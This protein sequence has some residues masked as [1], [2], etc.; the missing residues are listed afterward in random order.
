MTKRPMKKS[1]QAS[2]SAEPAPAVRYDVSLLTEQDLYLFNEGS[3]CRLYDKFGAHLTTADGVEGTYFSVWAPDAEQVYVMG[4]FNGWDKASHPLGARAQSGI[5]EGFVP[6]VGKGEAY[7]F[8][9]ASRYSGY[10]VDK[11]SP[12]GLYFEQ[13]P[14]TASIVWDLAYDWG[15]EAWMAKRHSRNALDGPMAVYEVHLGSWMRVP[16]EGNR[17]MTYRELAP[18]LAEYV[19][20]LGYTHVEFLPVMEHPF[21]GSWGYQTTG[22]FAPTSRYGTPQ[23]FMYSS[24]TYTDTTSASSWTGSRPTSPRTSTE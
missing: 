6:G 8:H 22:Y 24:T 3:H 2:P 15:D 1:S 5:W 13:P 19:S 21:F 7:K 4:D 23:D 10:R 9:L 18:R 14:K 20:R 17:P 12:F 11:P 16:E